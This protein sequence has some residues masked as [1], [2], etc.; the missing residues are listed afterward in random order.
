MA[1]GTAYQASSPFYVA[2]QHILR[3]IIYY[4][5]DRAED[6]HTSVHLTANLAGVIAQCVKQDKSA[7]VHSLSVLS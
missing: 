3:H 4:E 2:A 5:R 6:M 1:Q 7:E